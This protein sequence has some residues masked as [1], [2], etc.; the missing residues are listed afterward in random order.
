MKS[1]RRVMTM[2][3]LCLSLQTV[4]AQVR[5]ADTMIHKIFASLQAK[6]QKAF[7]ALYPNAE[8]FGRFIRGIMEQTMKS[9]EI[10]KLMA[11]LKKF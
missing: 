8:Q 6:D 2:A 9:E 7:V 4:Q 10:K 1:V 11:I 3:L 5:N